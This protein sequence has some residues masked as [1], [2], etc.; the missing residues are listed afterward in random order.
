MAGEAAGMEE[1]VRFL[2]KA[3]RPTDFSSVTEAPRIKVTPEGAAMLYARYRFAASFCEGKDVLEV[4]CAS[5]M[6]LGYLARHARSVVGGDYT[7]SLLLKAQ[8]HYRGR[9]PLVRLDAH[10]LPF[11]DASFDTAILF[12]AIYYLA[13]PQEFCKE[14]RRVLRKD[15]VLLLCSVNN[16]WE[17]FNP[18]PFSIRYFS[19]GELSAM[20]LDCGFQAEIFSAFSAN[21]AS[22]RQK[23]IAT[24]RK[25][26]VRLHLFP[27]TMNG[28]EILK[29]LFYGELVELREE[30][31]DGIAPMEPLSPVSN[32]DG[33][34]GHKVL[35]ALGRCIAA[36]EASRHFILF[37]APGQG[38][39]SL[40]TPR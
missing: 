4:G 7:E 30:I 26:A 22:L 19:A 39:T 35:Y 5:G 36:A 16:V 13:R 3:Q 11:R 40:H 14:C 37:P 17:G 32:G 1:M 27:K 34:N 28:K 8:S 24:A 33:A 29:R 31:E 23:V 21:P 15:G 20:L 2:R 38:S 9:L 10:A 25:T 18:S 6:G 12:E